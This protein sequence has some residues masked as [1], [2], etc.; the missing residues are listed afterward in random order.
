ML[1][2]ILI[3]AGQLPIRGVNRKHSLI[4]EKKNVIHLRVKYIC[5]VR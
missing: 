3:I 2:F 4:S 1:T 5:M